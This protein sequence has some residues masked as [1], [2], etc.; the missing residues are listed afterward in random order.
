MTRCININKYKVF[1]TLA[2]SQHY[3]HCMT[4]YK[5][6][7]ITTDR[8]Y[9]GSSVQRELSY[10]SGHAVFSVTKSDVPRPI[11]KYDRKSVVD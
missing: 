10:P 6:T 1:K 3:F 7:T 9:Y 5:P 4:T 8:K 11:I 2:I